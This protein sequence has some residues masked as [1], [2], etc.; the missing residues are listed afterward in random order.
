MEAEDILAIFKFSAQEKKMLLSFGIQEDIFLPLLLS[1]KSGG[2]WSYAAEESRSIAVKDVTTYYD[3]ENKAG[4][5]LEEVY[6]FIDPEIVKQEGRVYRLEKCGQKGER[7]LVTRP[8]RM[9]LKARKIVLAQV[10]PGKKKIFIREIE[11][12]RVSLKGS[13]AYS[14][15]HELEH[16]EKGE[17]RGLPFWN[18]EYIPQ[19]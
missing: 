16:L 8:Y 11:E 6:L 7:E 4:Y 3:E 15:A 12:K 14:A 5:T 18:F 13:P 1:L 17:V 2:S 9:T 19:L 10:D